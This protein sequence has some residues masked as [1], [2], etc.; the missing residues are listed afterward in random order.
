MERGRKKIVQLANL[1]KYEDKHIKKASINSIRK[2][3]VNNLIATYTQ[4]MNV[5]KYVITHIHLYFLPN[6]YE[7]IQIDK[8]R[9]K[10][11]KFNCFKL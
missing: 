2:S 3:K 10:H 8:L 4:F 6:K 1:S 5:Y 11:N 7:R 9:Y